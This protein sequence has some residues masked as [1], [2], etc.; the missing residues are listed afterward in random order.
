MLKKYLV[1]FFIIVGIMSILLAGCGEDVHGGM[2]LV[3]AGTTSEDNGLITV[4]YDFYIGKYHVTQ[5]EFEDVMDFNPSYFNDSDY[6]NLTG[7]SNNRPVETV[8][9]YDAVMYCNKLSELE[10]LEKYYEISDIEYE[11]DHIVDATVEENKGAN[12]LCC[13][14]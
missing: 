2:V 14:I 10:G 4:E 13:F 6:P 5:E 11:D 7:D 1:L 3:E 9:W 8:T 12:G